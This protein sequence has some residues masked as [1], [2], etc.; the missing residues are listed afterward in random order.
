MGRAEQTLRD[1]FL[2]MF[3]GAKGWLGVVQTWANRA[4]E[5]KGVKDEAGCRWDQLQ[6][7]QGQ[8]KAGGEKA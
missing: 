2:V 5:R 1:V 4:T 6:A 8:A 3:G 7:Q